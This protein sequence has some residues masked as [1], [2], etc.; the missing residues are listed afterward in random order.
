MYSWSRVYCVL[1]QKNNFSRI[2]HGLQRISFAAWRNYSEKALEADVTVIGSGPGG[3]VAAIKAAQLGFQTVCVEKNDTLGGTCLNVGCIPSK[4]LLNNSYLYHLAHGKDFANRGIEVTGISLNLEKMMEQKSGAVKSLTGGIAHLF[5]QNKVVHVQ[6]FGKIT[7]KNQ[8]TATKADGSTQVINTKNILIATGSE[9][10]PFPGIPIDE[11]TIVSST[12]A[13][14]LKQVP[15]KMV[16]I[17]AGVIGVELGSVWQRLGADVTAVE[18]LGHVG[19]VGIDMEISKNFQRILQKQ[20][21]K[22][23]LN[24]KVTGANKRPDGKIDVSIEAAAGGKEEVITCDV[25]LVCIGRRPFTENLGLQELGIEL[26]RGRIPINSRFQTKIPNIFAIGDV[27][28]GPMLAHK[29]EDEGIICVEGMAGGA[30]HID[31]NCVPSVIYTHPEVAWVGKSEEQLKEEGTEY[32]VGKFP[33][34]ANSRAKTN[35]DTD[36]LV[37][38]LG[39]KSTDRMLG[40][41]I[42]G[43]SAGEMINEAALAMEYGASCEDVARVCHAHPTVS[44]AFREANLAASFGK[45]INF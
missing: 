6:G 7:G 22:F 33:F 21:L 32:K 34:A 1:S 29:A 2:P 27:V 31:Y 20:G 25:L 26:D 28:A 19:G 17:G 43:A 13:L 23:K 4:A 40:A 44:E 5:K 38:I 15:E 39:H 16:V 12:G 42:L 18:F 35:A 11:E 24:T 8:V 14:S 41:H 9:V 37:K 36:G 45:A 3:Y 30:V 10:A